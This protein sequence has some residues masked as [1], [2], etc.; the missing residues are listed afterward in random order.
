MALVAARA[1]VGDGHGDCVSGSSHAVIAA[2]VGNGN[3]LAAGRAGRLALLESGADG[4]DEGGIRV[5]LPA[6]ADSAI[7]RED[8]A[9]AGV[10]VNWDEAHE[11]VT[12]GTRASSVAQRTTGAPQDEVKRAK[13]PEPRLSDLLPQREWI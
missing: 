5:G 6:G 11:L 8:G 7:L 12:M 13:G 10:T 4:D 9:E 2:N 3:L 1:R